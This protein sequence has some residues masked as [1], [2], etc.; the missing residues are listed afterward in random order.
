LDP[1]RKKDLQNLNKFDAKFK[2]SIVVGD[3]EVSNCPL[4]YRVVKHTKSGS[5]TVYMKNRFYKKLGVMF[6]LATII[7]GIIII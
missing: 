7:T 6:Q 4:G 2:K 1:Q 3:Y 5:I